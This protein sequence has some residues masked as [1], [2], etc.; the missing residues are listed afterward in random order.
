MVLRMKEPFSD[1]AP[2]AKSTVGDTL[3]KVST[4][5]ELNSTIVITHGIDSAVRGVV[6]PFA[7]LNA[8]NTY[9]G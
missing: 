1:L 9:F 2:Q 8:K 5:D 4:V 3:L 7:G 6:M